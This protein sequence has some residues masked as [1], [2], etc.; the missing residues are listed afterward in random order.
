MPVNLN[1]LDLVSYNN[2]YYGTLTWAI[3]TSGNSCGPTSTGHFRAHVGHNDN[4]ILTFAAPVTHFY[5]ATLNENNPGDEITV[6]N[7]V[8]VATIPSCSTGSGHYYVVS[9][10]APATVVTLYDV[11]SSGGTG[12]SFLIAECTD[13]LPAPTVSPTPELIVIIGGGERDIANDEASD[14]KAKAEII[15]ARAD[16]STIVPF[17]FAEAVAVSLDN[18]FKIPRTK[19]QSIGVQSGS[20]VVTVVFTNPPPSN[21]TA[22][23][24][25]TVEIMLPDG[26]IHESE[27]AALC[28]SGTSSNARSSYVCP[29]DGAADTSGSGSDDSEGGGTIIAIVIVIILLLC[30]VVGAVLYKRKQHREGSRGSGPGSTENSPEHANPTYEP[31]DGAAAE[32]QARI[33]LMGNSAAL[34]VGQALAEDAE[35]SP[36]KRAVENPLYADGGFAIKRVQGSV[37]EAPT[38]TA[39]ANTPESEG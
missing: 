32:S 7:G 5:I 18:T 15:F 10:N 2:T 3:T 33:G 31:P 22:L 28:A 39:V 35:L 8:V 37:R 34:T 23:D 30:C 11:S 19:I 21:M 25:A 16:Y 6:D 1:G 20:V 36:D 29:V 26:T 12:V 14:S 9:L 38:Q 27:P 4:A 17:D 13:S 24:S